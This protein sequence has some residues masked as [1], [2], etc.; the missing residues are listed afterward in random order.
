MGC[1]KFFG[2][3]LLKPRKYCCPSL[4]ACPLDVSPR[5][6]GCLLKACIDTYNI[7]ERRMVIVNANRPLRKMATAGQNAAGGGANGGYVQQSTQRRESAN[8]VTV[9]PQKSAAQRS[10]QLKKAAALNSARA[11]RQ[12]AV[13]NSAV[14][15]LLSSSAKKQWGCRKCAGCLVEDCGQCNY[16]LDK[17]KFGGPNTLK[18]KCINRRCNAMPE[19]TASSS[20]TPPPQTTNGNQ[21]NSSSTTAS[22][23]YS[24]RVDTS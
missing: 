2:R 24:T 22:L 9:T 3:F 16:C 10:A 12:A 20:P 23:R 11:Y 7:D 14:R 17:P 15:A 5:C 18:K 19:D 6:K 4:G 13:G 21:R 1:A 8:T